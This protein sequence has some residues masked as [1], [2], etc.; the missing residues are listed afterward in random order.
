MPLYHFAVQDGVRFDDP[1][2]AVFATDE[3]AITHGAHVAREIKA[4][5]GAEPVSDW[6]V[7]IRDGVRLVASI[8]ISTVQ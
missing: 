5:V 8:P 7:E 1:T 4:G 3:I 2:G 6:S